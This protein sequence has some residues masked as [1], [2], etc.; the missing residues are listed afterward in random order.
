MLLKVRALKMKLVEIH[1]PITIDLNK[2]INKKVKSFP[3]FSSAPVC[4][5]VT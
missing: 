3:S 5:P 2:K 4:V 1:F